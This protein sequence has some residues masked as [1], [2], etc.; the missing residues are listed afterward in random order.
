MVSPPPSFWW[1]PNL[2]ELDCSLLSAGVGCQED[3]NLLEC[4]QVLSSTIAIWLI[5]WAWCKFV[6]VFAC[7][8]VSHHFLQSGAKVTIALHFISP[9]FYLFS[10]FLT[11]KPSAIDV[12]P[13]YLQWPRNMPNLHPISIVDHGLKTILWLC[14]DND[15]VC[16]SFLDYRG[17][18]LKI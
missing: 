5:L 2:N 6:F 11:L 9:W 18:P 10:N 4:L 3:E 14:I 12:S 8:L 16:Y 7:M 17:W 1:L 13:F 15:Y